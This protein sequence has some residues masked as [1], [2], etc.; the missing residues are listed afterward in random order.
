M[1]NRTK[2]WRPMLLAIA[3]IV[4]VS[5][6]FAPTEASAHWRGRGW[7][8]GGPAIGLGLGL[9]L[10]AGYPYYARPTY[11][12]PAYGGYSDGCWRRVIV[13]TPWGPRAR[14]VWVCG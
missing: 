8:W 7:G 5:A 4:V 3:A 9:G 14:N 12:Y 13:E 1:L 6:T 10:A 11:G 2:F